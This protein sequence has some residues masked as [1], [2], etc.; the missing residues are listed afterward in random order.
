MK[1]RTIVNA[2]N[3]YALMV[4]SPYRKK[5]RP[6]DIFAMKFGDEFYLHGRVIRD[7]AYWTPSGADAGLAILVYIYD[8]IA[9]SIEDYSI[10]VLTTTNL[11]IPPVMTN[12]LAWTRGYFTTVDHSPLKSSD[13]LARHVFRNSDK[14]DWYFDESGQEV[15]AWDG[16]IGVYG[17]ASFRAVERVVLDAL[18]LLDVK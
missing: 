16:P 6:G 17:L 13:T 4:I 11:L 15:S 12:K 18:G 8:H 5:I 2:E 14:P 9:K 3:K 10:G 7:D 1:G